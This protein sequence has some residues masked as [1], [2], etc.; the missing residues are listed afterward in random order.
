[1]YIPILGMG[2]GKAWDEINMKLFPTQILFYKQHRKALLCFT[3]PK[4]LR[5][6]GRI[7]VPLQQHVSKSIS[8]TQPGRQLRAPSR[9]WGTGSAQPR[10]PVLRNYNGRHGGSRELRGARSRAEAAFAPHIPVSLAHPAA[11]GAAWPREGPPRPVPAPRSQ[12]MLCRAVRTW[13][14][15]MSERGKPSASTS[16]SCIPTPFCCEGRGGGWEG[17]GPARRPPARPALPGH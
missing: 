6:S 8:L 2:T 14:R 3:H 12:M 15:S 5:S 9:T 4:W 7:S 1:M 13:Y 16:G 11:W 17:A 10:A